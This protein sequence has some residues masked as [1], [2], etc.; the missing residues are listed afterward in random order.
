MGFQFDPVNFGL[1]FGAGVSTAAVGY[2]A[3]RFVQSVRP[4]KSDTLDLRQNYA[5]RVL[6]KRFITELSAFC[7]HSHIAGKHIPL[8]DFLVEPRFIQLPPLISRPEEG[9]ETDIFNIIPRIHDSPFLHAPYNIPS[10]GIDEMASGSRAIALLGVPGSGRSTSLKVIA[11]WSMGLLDFNMPPDEVQMQLDKNEKTLSN[12]QQTERIKDRIRVTEEARE[13]LLRETGQRGDSADSSEEGS[14]RTHPFK[15]I[16]PLYVHLGNIRL[17]S[18]GLGNQIDPAEPLVRALQSQVKRSTARSL[19]QSTYK[20]LESGRALVLLDG[21]DEIPEADIPDLLQWL[22]AFIAMYEDNF[23]IVTGLP[24]GY[25]RFL[26]MGFTPLFLRPWDDASAQYHAEGWLKAHSKQSPD[27]ELPEDWVAE[28][29]VNSRAYSP[30]QISLQTWASKSGHSHRFDASA[31]MQNYLAQH[32]DNSEGWLPQIKRLATLETNTGY[33]RAEDLI[34]LEE[35]EML[36][37]PSAQLKNAGKAKKAQ[38]TET[39]KKK[40]EAEAAAEPLEDL[41]GAAKNENEDDA[42]PDF[43]MDIRPEQE[44]EQDAEDLSKTSDPES[45][46]FMQ[47]I[48]Q[49]EPTPSDRDQ[50][51]QRRQINRDMRAMLK[52]LHS[53]GV[54]VLYQD[55]RYRFAHRSICAYFASLTLITQDDATYLELAMQPAW[56]EASAYAAQHPAAERV[57]REYLSAPADVLHNNVVELAQYLAYAGST[58]AWR[59]LFLRIMGNLFIAPNQF[60]STRER[61]AAALIATHDEGA[62]VIFR[63]AVQN[64]NADLRRIGSLC[65]GVMRDTAAVKALTQLLSDPDEGVQI[66]ATLAISAIGTEDALLTMVDALQ[67]SPNKAVRRA[68]AESFATNREEG[69]LTLY[70]ASESEDIM[71]RR[72]AVWGLGRIRT[73]WSLITL[74]RIF[75]EDPEWYVRSAAQSVFIEQ[76]ENEQRGVQSYPSIGSVTWLLQWSIEQ[77][78]EGN[79]PHNIGGVHLLSYAIEQA[80]D[81]MIRLLAVVTAGQLCITDVIKELY[82]RLEDPEDAIRDAAYRSIAE[83]QFQTDQPLPAPA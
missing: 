68:V 20:L 15:R 75:L 83:I 7:Q 74:N 49:D 69:Y 10:I 23:I 72:A 31:S 24:Q 33:I 4:D 36:S 67:L 16:A 17:Q 19:P 52:E 41:P 62:L 14:Q 82:G 2:Q 40:A 45:L 13:K 21:L 64:P 48:K 57:I 46:S 60:S 53:A 44:Y 38:T 77:A 5:Q 78:Q 47:D 76:Y 8:S 54:L 58:V 34:A 11:L 22:T 18:G 1:G 25:S 39:G 63:R 66:A 56:R 73:P 50:A 70:D 65:L 37:Y 43:L 3:Y 9:E 55:S 26:E 28:R 71:L 32:L 6:D 30:L 79:I 80:E 61:I 12:E 42:Y 51:Q 81:P 29:V 27:Q 59:N 35:I